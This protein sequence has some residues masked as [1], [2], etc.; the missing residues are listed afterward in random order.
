MGQRKEA[1]VKRSSLS[2]RRA[3]QAQK[4]LQIDRDTERERGGGKGVEREWNRQ[5]NGQQEDTGKGV[6]R[7]DMLMLFLYYVQLLKT[8]P[9]FVFGHACV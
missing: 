1:H 9:P 6:L 3:G 5:A 8:G 2:A 4:A 7:K